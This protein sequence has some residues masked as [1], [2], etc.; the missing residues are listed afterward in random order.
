[1]PSN[2]QRQRGAVLI[3]SLMILIALTVAAL[4]TVGS[5][6][7][8][9]LAV[10]NVQSQREAEAAAQEGI[11]MVLS[12]TAFFVPDFSGPESIDIGGGR[13]VDLIG[14]QC[15]EWTIADGY[16]ATVDNAPIEAHWWV[17]ARHTT[18]QAASSTVHQGVWMRMTAFGCISTP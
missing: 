10:G 9:L 17:T 15:R 11:E 5:S 3:V 2:T 4:S 14:M 13:T 18:P 1:M 6:T 16:S 12:G 8:P 7:T